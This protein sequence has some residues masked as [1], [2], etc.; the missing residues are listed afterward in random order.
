MTFRRKPLSKGS[1]RLLVTD[2]TKFRV[3]NAQYTDI[4]IQIQSQKDR[5]IMIASTHETVPLRAMLKQK[6]YTEDIDTLSKHFFSFWKPMWQRDTECEATDLSQWSEALQDI[7][8]P[9]PPREPIS[10]VWD[11]PRVVRA[12]IQRMKPFTA[13][14]LDGWRAQELQM[15]PFRAIED[16]ASIF[17]VIWPTN[18]TATQMLA[19]VI[20]LVKITNP[21]TFSDGRPIT[22]LGYIPRLTSK[23]VADQ[24]LREWGKSWD[25]QIAGGL[26]FRAVKD[27]TIQQ[28]YI[29]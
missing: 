15:L 9:I 4:P 24:L 8:P 23:L 25:P 28:P 19:R 22:I 2:D 18:L 7:I 26:P 1:I 5:L 12:T 14:G 16:L 11:D 21:E 6:R 27:I 10:V 13:P 17:H 29:L 3:G 20:L